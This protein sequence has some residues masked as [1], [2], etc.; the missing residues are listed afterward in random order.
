MKRK[1]LIIGNS[2]KKNTDEYLPGVKNDVKNFVNYL[3]SNNGGRWVD[4]EILIS[5]DDSINEVKRKIDNFKNSYADYAFVVFSGHGSFSTNFN[6][7]KLYIFDD[8]I[9]ESSILKTSSKQLTVIDTCAGIEN[10]TRMLTEGNLSMEHALSKNERTK[11]YR[12]LFEQAIQ[13]CSPQQIIL[14]SCEKGQSSADAEEGGLYSYN[15]LRVGSEN[16]KE[17]LT[18]LESHVIAKDLVEKDI[19]TDQKPTSFLSL[20]T[21]NK[22]PFSIGN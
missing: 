20:R 16:T 1:A 22:L 17:L 7:R 2:G 11:D 14:Y 4:N 19:R 10:D 5:L 8:Y 9:L 18:S 13:K 21:G 3:K 15:L 12:F 6:C